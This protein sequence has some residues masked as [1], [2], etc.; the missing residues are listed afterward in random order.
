MI[1]AARGSPRVLWKE[2]LHSFD[3]GE[4]TEEV[5]ARK[6]HKERETEVVRNEVL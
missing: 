3:L 5:M 4:H 2:H 1:N 6:K